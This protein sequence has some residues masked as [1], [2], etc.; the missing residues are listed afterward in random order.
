MGAIDIILDK[1]F[2]ESTTDRHRA[3][4]AGAGGELLDRQSTVKQVRALKKS[5]LWDKASLV[6]IPSARK[7]GAL[8]CVKPTNGSGDFDFSRPSI[9]F[10]EKKSLPLEQVATHLPALEWSNSLQ[11]FVFKIDPQRTNDYPG[12][13]VVIETTTGITPTNEQTILAPDGT[14]SAIRIANS[15]PNYCLRAQGVNGQVRSIFARTISGSGIVSLMAVSG[16]SKSLFTLT[17][18]WRKFELPVDTS[19]SGGS[20]FYLVDFRSP[21]CTLSEILVWNP[22]V[23]TGV[24]ATTPIRTPPSASLTRARDNFSKLIPDLIGQQEGTLY[25]HAQLRKSLEVI[26][27]NRETLNCIALYVTAAGYLRVLVYAASTPLISV[28]LSEIIT[29]GEW[30]KIAF[31]YKTGD[32]AYYVNGTLVYSSSVEYSFSSSLNGIYGGTGGF[33]VSIQEPYAI[34]E[35]HLYKSRLSNSELEKLT[36]K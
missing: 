31:A 36:L 28:Q 19:D 29:D 15:S 20:Y 33:A 32:S 14:L 10:Q 5:G 25:V 27:I 9:T 4:V 21:Y 8:F 6:M 34:A 3:R 11:K 26:S 7:T 13:S 16:L 22:Q 12:S 24:Y 17:E 30:Y 1:D 18:E 2:A 23:E 35:I